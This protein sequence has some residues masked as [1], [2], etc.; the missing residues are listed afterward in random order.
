MN[1]TLKL[2]FSETDDF[3]KNLEPLIHE[4]AAKTDSLV[5]KEPTLGYKPIIV[6]NDLYAGMRLNT[7]LSSDFYKFGI[8]VGHHTFGKV[9]YQFS[10]LLSLL[11]T[12][13]RQVTWF[14]QS[15]A[16]MAS[17]WFLDYLT[18]LWYENCPDPRY[19]GEY[20]VFEAL[21]TEKIKTAYQNIDIMLNLATNEWIKEEIK[22]L[23]SGSNYTS[24]IMLDHI[25]LELLPMFQPIRRPT[26][27]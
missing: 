9:A 5:G 1:W 20:K 21:K 27:C 14:S 3:N 24:P 4:I 22:Q 10:N 12:D 17:F 15:L 18:N 23:C 16:H 26:R 19:E 13:P 7:P 2:D 25:G 8:T 11:Y 6:T